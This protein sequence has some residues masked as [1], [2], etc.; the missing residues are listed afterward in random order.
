MK[1]QDFQLLD[2]SAKLDVFIALRPVI[3]DETKIGDEIV[4]LFALFDFFA[5]AKV[6]ELSRKATSISGIDINDQTII[7]LLDKISLDSLQA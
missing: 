7:N 3:I 6:Q 1:L 2:L 4:Y 5:E